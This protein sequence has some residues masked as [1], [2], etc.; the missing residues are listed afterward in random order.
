MFRNEFLAG[1]MTSGASLFLPGDPAPTA[2]PNSTTASTVNPYERCDRNYVLPYNQ[3]L[4]F[5]HRALDEP[6]VD[7]QAYRGNVVLLNFFATWCGPCIAEQPF[8][9]EAA[10][11]YFDQ[12]LRVIGI[13][14]REYDDHVRLYRDKYHIHYPIVMDQDGGLFARVEN[15]NIQ[16]RVV[17]PITLFLSEQGMM[18]CYRRGRMSQDELVYK[19]ERMLSFLNKK[20]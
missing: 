3:P 12:G 18:T 14:Y 15:N 17:F 20:D 5:K 7:L 11:K 6:D 9:V 4:W 1:L 10:G 19:I 13:N 8:L 16:D 2:S